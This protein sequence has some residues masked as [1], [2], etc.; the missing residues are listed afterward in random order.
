[1]LR[2]NVGNADR[3]LRIVAGLVL[4]ALVFV[5][6]KTAWGWLGLIPLTTGLTRRCPAY[7]PFGISTC[8][9]R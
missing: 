7:I 8:R 6:P 9:R 3:I 5:G 1:M 4:I 2:V